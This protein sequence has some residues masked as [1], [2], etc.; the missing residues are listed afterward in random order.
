MRGRFSGRSISPFVLIAFI[1]LHF[2]LTNY[3]KHDILLRMRA[4]SKLPNYDSL[5]DKRDNLLEELS[6]N[7]FILRG[8]LRRHG[9]ICGRPNCSCKRL[10]DPKLHGPYDYL[11]H[12][13]ADKTQTVFLNKKKFI[14]AKKGI[15]NYKKLTALIYRLS[16]M[17]FRLL[18][19]HYDKL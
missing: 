17:N 4:P 12:R 10:N 6:A 2:Y 18:R 7:A 13:Y 5:R 1:L 8:S 19:Y 15:S 14:L 3:P 16:E 11:S 9:N